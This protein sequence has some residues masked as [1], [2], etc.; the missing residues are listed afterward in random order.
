MKLL[1]AAIEVFW[2]EHSPFRRMSQEVRVVTEMSDEELE[3]WT[4]RAY[5]EAVEDDA[6]CLECGVPWIVGC[7]L[8]CVMNKKDVR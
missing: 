5:W 8:W 6:V 1:L 3:E 2:A 7:P 4:D